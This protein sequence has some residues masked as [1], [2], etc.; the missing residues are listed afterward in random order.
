MNREL[1]PLQKE[2]LQYQ[3]KLPQVLAT[4][5]RNIDIEEGKKTSAISDASEIEKLFPNSFGKPIVS[6]KESQG[7]VALEQRNVGV[8][9]SGGQAPGGHNV[10]AGLYDA[11][12]EA[13]SQNKLFGFL[14]GPAGIM[15]AKYVEFTD[16]FID[17][18]RNTGGFDIIGSVET[19]LKHKLILNR[20]GKLAKI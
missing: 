5:I 17:E 7:N 1:S 18:Y 12:K 15:N 20:L 10:I 4:G 8:I 14:G 3:P 16:C 6:F 19:S 13:N 11:L 9:L 2:R